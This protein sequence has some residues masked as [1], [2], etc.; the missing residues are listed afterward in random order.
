[1]GA[2]FNALA[3]AT[4]LS[5]LVSPTLADELADKGRKIFK[6]NQRSVVT[7]QIVIK[8]KMSFGGFG[9]R[10]NESKQ[11]VTGTLIEPNGL[12]VLS[13]SATDPGGMFQ[14]IMSGMS[15]ETEGKFKMDTELSDVK[16]LLEDGAE[17]P[18]EIVLRD[19]DLDLAFVRP[20]TNLTTLLPALD[21]SK[22]AKADVFDQV[23][24]LHR[25]GKAANRAYAASFERIAATVQKPRLFYVP[26]SNLTQTALGS[27]AFDLEGQVV[28]IFVMR[29]TKPSGGMMSM[30]S[31]GAGFMTAV[32]VPADDV[33]KAAKQAPPVKEPEKNEGKEQKKE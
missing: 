14:T 26:D 6:A 27:P 9:G 30:M 19:K 23:V 12:T 5:L 33:L 28:G 22:S 32:I 4:G 2:T 18:S 31:G 16:I 3:I 20:K 11:D 1:M 7:V 15:D 29:A 17:I 25:L 8:S 10:D 21:L 13:L 24:A